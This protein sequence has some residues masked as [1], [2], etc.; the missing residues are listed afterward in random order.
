MN[1]EREPINLVNPHPTLLDALPSAPL[2]SIDPSVLKELDFM[3]KDLLAG[4]TSLLERPEVKGISL[5]Q[6]KAALDFILTDPH[7]SNA[8]KQDLLSNSWRVNFR[9]KP[10]TPEEFLTSRYLGETANTIYPWVRKAFIEFL[11]PLK[12]Y[13]TLVLNPYI[14]FG[15][16]F[17]VVLVNLFLGMNFSMMRAPWRYLGHSPATVY[18]QVYAATSLKKSSELL[19][20]PMLNMLQASEFFEKVHSKDAMLERDRDFSRMGNIDKIY[21]T[22]AVPTS[23]LQ[24]SGGAN[25][26]LISNPNGLLG[27]TI[28]V[29]NMTELSFFSDA[30]KSDDFVFKF[31]TKLRSRIE[32]RMKSNYFGRFV[33]DSSPNSLENPIDDW[34]V[35]DAPKN[36]ENYIVRGSR[37]HFN[38][39]DFPEDTFDEKG[40][41]K[42]DKA[43]FVFIGGKGK[44][45]IV[46]DRASVPEYMPDVI[47]VPKILQEK[48]GARKD[49][50]ATFEE[51]LFEAL[52]DQAGIPAGSSDKIFYDGSVVDRVFVP[53]LRSFYKHLT[54]PSMDAPE[55]LIWNQVKD[56]FFIRSLD[57]YRFW[58]NPHLPRV[59][60]V[61]QS[62]SGD[63]AA[64][65][66]SHVEKQM[67][68]IRAGAE[69]SGGDLYENVYIN[70]MLI[71]ITPAGGRIN[72]DAIRCFITDLI[73]EG[74]LTISKVS[75]DRFQSE[76][77]VQSL[78]RRGLE[79]E[80]LSVD[81]TIEPYI[82]FVGLVETGRF[83]M[84]HNIHAKNN[85]RSLQMV[86]R[87]DATGHKTGTMKI[88]HTNGDL[89]YEGD[90]NWLTS[91]IGIH[92]KDG[93]DVLAANCELLRKY[94]FL[95]HEIFDP[96]KIV[97][98]TAEQAKID[99]MKR[100]Q[101]MGLRR[102]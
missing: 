90:E 72:L 42:D 27:Q 38:K 57:R 1:V 102:P 29:G 59:V 62:I 70:D 17:M 45:P 69:V 10:P 30:G 60:S 34:I 73:D 41:V 81:K 46:I 47:K 13:R 22:T 97:E 39:R 43:F 96:D 55:K 35:N 82:G 75:F 33:L 2:S 12:P 78:L 49:Y 21:W 11:D 89:V 20:E 79:V 9:D 99:T 3:L 18:T 94:E 16:S 40:E 32:S 4:D 50:Q 77:A 74:M 48:D 51:N 7:M 68:T 101:T 92:A 100:L 23:A 28:A 14:G 65:G 25:F 63:V 58:R 98:K 66:V 95:G 87:K 52:K 5:P 26:K 85:M 91:M 31:F 64:I 86:K 67:K 71:M 15:K 93:A 61:D 53:K 56:I 84:G 88:D 44:P 8:E 36:P 19:L 83:K 24:F 76:P 54:A 6:I 80:F 37:W